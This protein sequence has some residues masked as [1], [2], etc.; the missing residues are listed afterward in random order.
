MG[1]QTPRRRRPWH[2]GWQAGVIAVSVAAVGLALGAPRAVP[3]VDLPVPVPRQANLDATLAQHLRRGARMAARS[4]EARVQRFDQRRVGEAVRAFGV[5]DLAR[6]QEALFGAKRELLAAVQAL[7]ERPDGDEQ[8]RELLGY[9]LSVFLRELGAWRATG[10]ASP[11]LGELAGSITQTITESGWLA[12]G[13]RLVPDVHVQAALFQKRFAELTSAREVVGL[14]QDQHR[15][16]I[17][18][19]IAHP[20]RLDNPVALASYRARRVEEAAQV[21]DAYPAELARAMVRQ[22]AGDAS[23]AIEAYRKHFEL[24][25]DGPWTLRARNHLKALEAP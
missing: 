17:A 23:G 19:L 10:Q 15:A 14:N 6:D 12:P 8:L 3:P 5:A 22:Q 2:E 11:E 16:L 9:Q 4:A 18:F 24:H 21:D 7:R 1:A 20:P 13:R 25:P